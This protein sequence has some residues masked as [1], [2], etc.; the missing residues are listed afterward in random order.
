MSGRIRNPSVRALEAQ[1]D[2]YAVEE[3]APPPQRAARKQKA[4]AA[5]TSAPAP[6]RKGNAVIR[7]LDTGGDEDTDMSAPASQEE[8][9]EGEKDPDFTLY[10]I[11]LGFDTGEQPMIQC[12]HCNNWFH[13]RCIGLDEE[14]AG[15]IEAYCCDIC[16]EMGVGTTRRASLDRLARLPSV[17]GSGAVGFARAWKALASGALLDVGQSIN[18]APLQPIDYDDGQA[19]SPSITGTFDEDEEEPPTADDDD[20]EYSAEAGPSSG[21]IKRAR[22]APGGSKQRTRRK[23]SNAEGD[24]DYVGDE[25]VP[26]TTA[27][28]RSKA[29]PSHPKAS[30]SK[31]GTRQGSFVDD[32]DDDLAPKPKGRAPRK[33][34]PTAPPPPIDIANAPSAPPSDKTRTHC[35]NQLTAIFKS[36]FSAKEG[37]ASSVGVEVRAAAFAESVEAELFEGFAELDPKNVRS[38]RT[39]YVAKFRSLHFNLKTNAVFRGR[40]S[41]S[42]LTPAQIVNMSNEDLLTPELKAM[43]D[44]VRAASLKHSVKEVATA[45]TAKRTHKGEEEIDNHA[46]VAAEAEEKALAERDER[47]RRQR[48]ESVSQRSPQPSPRVE[49]SPSFF[50]SP[51]ATA[52]ESSASPS[53]PF[54]GA[55]APRHR[56]SLPHSSVTISAEDLGLDADDEKPI[57]PPTPRRKAST[58]AHPFDSASPVSKTEDSPAPG[59]G[60]DMPPPPPPARARSSFDMSSVWG[61]I[62]ASPQLESSEKME[63]TETDATEGEE[64]EG[65]TPFTVSSS[66]TGDDDD[67]EASL[68]R[69][70]GAAKEKAPRSTTPPRP[71]STAQP[72]PEMPQVWSGDLIVPDEGGFPA[73]GVQVGGRPF[74]TASEVWDQMLPRSF[75]M[76]GRM[77]TKTAH[78]YLLECSFASSRELVVIAVLPD[79]NGPTELA[80]EKPTKESCLAKHKHIFDFY[81]K[82]DRIGVIA[83]TG[84]LKKVVKDIYFLPLRKW[85]PLP[86]WAELMDDHKIPEPS[87]RDGDVLLCVLVT[88]K[89]V[90]P[91]VKPPSPLPAPTSAPTSTPSTS[92]PAVQDPAPVS[93]ALPT[94]KPQPQAQAQAPLPLPPSAPPHHGASPY[95]QP[96]SNYGA[97]PLS[98]SPYPAGGQSPYDRLPSNYYQP[99]HYP[100]GP[101]PASYGQPSPYPQ[102]SPHYPQHSPP[103]NQRSPTYNQQSPPYGGQRSPPYGSRSPL[104]DPS[105]PSSAPPPPVD[106][107][108]ILAGID[109]SALSSLLSNPS[110]IQSAVA[111]SQAP[112]SGYGMQAQAP[113]GGQQWGG[114]YDGYGAGRPNDGGYGYGGGEGQP[115]A[116]GGG[117]VHPSRAA[118]MDPSA[119][120]PPGDM[121]YGGGYGGYD[122]GGGHQGGYGGGRGGH[123][124][125]YGSDD[126]GGWGGGRGRG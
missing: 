83:P 61:N 91:S 115:P 102:H 60:G 26:A 31:K 105:A 72:L 75:A 81:V 69:G 37:E 20:E 113:M 13:F 35:V 28:P 53:T 47:E 1:R 98:A 101:P 93:S 78:K 116:G 54:A 12:E 51:P 95:P 7:G 56:S 45:P 103:Y 42:D 100:R 44:T 68:L 117:Y 107:A 40:I 23:V 41:S 19:S 32:K 80:P 76:D 50:G 74:G 14:R 104:Y 125:G 4:A 89:G 9:G 34:A 57:K 77:P 30:T 62:K 111:Q 39:K 49:A 10:C 18:D 119:G 36:I 64:S 110:L 48:S 46:V 79:L 82:K 97:P 25:E 52:A 5:S 123:Q 114:G 22:K 27:S 67:F 109:T 66:K 85:D 17:V 29:T 55:S 15:L 11:C 58:S 6:A 120:P 96:N 8:Q 126:G 43:A 59:E 71:P 70:D 88:Q 3:L 73:Y 16:T 90:I 122:N 112:S 121:G 124:Q 84:E 2:A 87:G 65:P 33:P 108:S 38:P 24:E 21:G 86:E 94:S 118:M 63:S 92:T 106:A 99:P